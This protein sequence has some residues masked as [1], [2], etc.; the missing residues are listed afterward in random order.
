MKQTLL[1][2]AKY[3]DHLPARSTPKGRTLGI[4]WTIQSLGS[5]HIKNHIQKIGITNQEQIRLL[6]TLLTKIMIYFNKMKITKISLSR[7][8]R[9]SSN[10]LSSMTN[11]SKRN[12]EL[13]KQK[14]NKCTKT[15]FSTKLLILINIA[16]IHIKKNWHKKRT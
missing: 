10:H 4:S 6:S 7:H 8:P 3:Q 14:I 12:Q 1:C 16:Y 5:Y 9:I 11:S 13:C 2:L 15:V